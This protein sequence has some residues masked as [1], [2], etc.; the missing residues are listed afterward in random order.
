MRVDG[1]V[2]EEPQFRVLGQTIAI[3]PNATVHQYQRLFLVDT[4]LPDRFAL[5]TTR[6]N[7]PTGGEFELPDRHG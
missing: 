6:V 1:K 4:G 3:D 5:P 2:V 7:Q